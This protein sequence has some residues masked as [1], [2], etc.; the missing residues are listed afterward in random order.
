VI[1]KPRHEHS[2]NFSVSWYPTLRAFGVIDTDNSGVILYGADAWAFD[3]AIHLQPIMSESDAPMFTYKMRLLLLWNELRTDRAKLEIAECAAEGLVNNRLT[4]NQAR[5]QLEAAGL[6]PYTAVEAGL[7]EDIPR[8]VQTIQDA[9]TYAQ[10]LE[11][12][13]KSRP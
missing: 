13:R 3:A 1:W 8:E 10:A 5:E 7:V 11:S 6:W 12:Y 9:A 4:A 2:I